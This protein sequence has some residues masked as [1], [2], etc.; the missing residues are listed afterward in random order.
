MVSG[1][2]RNPVA[3][4]LRVAGMLANGLA[5]VGRRF[6]EWYEQNEPEV[7]R[8]LEV[9]AQVMDGLPNWMSLCAVTFARGGW[10]AAPLGQMD[11][12]EFMALVE[13][14]RDEPDD[15][16]RC[17]LDRVVPEYFRRDDH[18]RLR[19]MVEEWD[20]EHFGERRRVFEEALWAHTHGRFTLPIHGLAPQIEGVLRDVTGMHKQHDTWM[21]SFNEAFGFA[22]SRKHPADPDWTRELTEFW[23]K[24]LDERY[25]QSEAF[26]ARFALLRINELY[27]NGSFSDPGFTSARARRHPIAHGV[28]KNHDEIESLRLFCALDLLHDAV[29][30]YKRLETARRSEAGPGTAHGGTSRR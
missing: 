23:A 30:E 22:Y 12:S 15:V 27:V 1:R 20:D 10:S 24:P 19:E 13:R 18:A 8:F 9:A 17:E 21:D 3:D 29:G 7:R 14:L 25:Q 16:V 2:D 28:F 6:G 26:R 5:E 4:F 11:L